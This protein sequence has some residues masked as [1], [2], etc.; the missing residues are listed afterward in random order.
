MIGRP[1]VDLV[2]VGDVN[3]DGDGNVDMDWEP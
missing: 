2:L 1:F 3:L